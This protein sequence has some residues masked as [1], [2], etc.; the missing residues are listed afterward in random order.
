MTEERSSNSNSDFKQIMVDFNKNLL[1]IQNVCNNLRIDLV[2]EKGKTAKLE[3]KN[4]FLENKIKS[5]DLKTKNEVSDLK[6]IIDQKDEKINSLEKQINKVNAS[7]DE[8]IGELTLELRTLNNTTCKVFYIHIT[9]K[10]K[11]IK[12]NCCENNCINKDNPYGNCIKGNGFINIIDDENIKYIKHIKGKGRDLLA[13]VYPENHFDK[14]EDCINYSLFYYEVKCKFEKSK[15]SYK[16]WM[17]IGLNCN[18]D[19]V[20]LNFNY[21]SIDYKIQNEVKEFKLPRTFSWNDGDIFGCGLVY[22]PT[23]KINELPYIFFT[24]NGRQIGKN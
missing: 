5:L 6:Q 13:I 23:N 17:D 24:Q 18:D 12:W 9:N 14:P 11:E 2:E 15:K 3:E 10:W 22:P 16:N 4:Q 20:K 1:D 19:L 7:F 8:K 21:H